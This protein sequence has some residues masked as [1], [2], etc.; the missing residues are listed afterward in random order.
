MTWAHPLVR[1]ARRSV[2]A[3]L[4][5]VVCAIV[6]ATISM[7]VVVLSVRGGYPCDRDRAILAHTCV[8]SQMRAVVLHRCVQGARGDAYVSEECMYVDLT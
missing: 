4:G 1:I 5:I 7:L 3:E 8:R 6:H 2:R